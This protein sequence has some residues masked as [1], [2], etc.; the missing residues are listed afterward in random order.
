MCKT[1]SIVKSVLISRSLRVIVS[2]QSSDAHPVYAEVPHGSLLGPTL[3]LIFINDFPS[4]VINSLRNIFT[5]DASPYSY[6]S[7]QVTETN[8]ADSLNTDL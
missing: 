7:C 5:Y 3:L 1:F 2:G 4:E 6:T 8:I